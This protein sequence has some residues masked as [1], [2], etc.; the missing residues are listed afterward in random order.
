MCV[1]EFKDRF[2]LALYDVVY[3]LAGSA[4]LLL[5]S[6]VIVESTCRFTE[7]NDLSVIIVDVEVRLIGKGEHDMS[8]ELPM[9]ISE[10]EDIRMRIPLEEP[11]LRRRI[12][13]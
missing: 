9:G 7:G 2:P 11:E 6:R 4:S 12:L 1:V 3:P 13:G 5:Q 10:A 8:E